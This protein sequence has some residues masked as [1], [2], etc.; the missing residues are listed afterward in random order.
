MQPRYQIFI[1]ST[2]KDLEKE[3][4]AVLKAVLE[5]QHFPSGMELFTASNSAPWEVIEKLIEESDYYVLVIGGKYG[6]MDEDGISFTER[7]YDLAVKLNKHV[8]AFPHAEPEKLTAD[9]FELDPAI[10]EKLEKFKKKVCRHLLK[11]YRTPEDLRGNVLASLAIA[12][13]KFPQTGWVKKSGQDKQEL[14]SKIIGLQDE[15]L[16][17]R[18]ENKSLKDAA[19]GWA[20]IDGLARGDE[21]LQIEFEIAVLNP[22][23][24]DFLI[25]QES[26]SVTTHVLF[27]T[28]D[29]V[30]FFLAY[31][32]IHQPLTTNDL[33]GMY[34]PMLLQHF[35]ETEE[36]KRLLVDHKKPERWTLNTVNPNIDTILLQLLGLGLIDKTH[37]EKPPSKG[38]SPWESD[39][40]GD[41]IITRWTLTKRG[42]QK[43]LLANGVRSQQTS[44]S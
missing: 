6:S 15:N 14:M 27:F 7:E 34:H 19:S 26:Q 4:E 40:L 42:Q 30:F 33:R 22:N 24:T 31:G 13:Q 16:R 36:Y 20:E 12:F 17:L 39:S 44:Q 25:K 32:L 38:R 1:S 23:S 3:R 11:P 18:E 10:R 28:W 5:L 8:L 41:D 21:K 2:F 9:K 37:S 35:E 29:E 43:Y